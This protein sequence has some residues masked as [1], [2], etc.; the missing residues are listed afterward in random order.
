MNFLDTVLPHDPLPVFVLVMMF[1]LFLP[2]IFER[3]K[4]PGL[5]GLIISGIILGPQ[6]LNI[7]TPDGPIIKFLADVGKLMVMFFAGLEIDM[8]QFKR[9][10][11]K[12]AIYGL[13]TFSFPLITGF[14]V[15]IIFGYSAISSLLIGSL[16]A[17][18]TLLAIPILIR[19]KIIKRES[20]TIT[21][22]ATMFT[23]I[24]SLVVL[25]VCI[26]IHTVGFNAA[27]LS[28][29]F[30]GMAVFIP[31]L[32]LISKKI[33]P[34]CLNR[35]QASEDSQTLYIFLIMIIAAVGAEKIHLEG[36]VGAFIAGLAVGETIKESPIREKLDTIGNTFFIPMFFL[37]V[38]SI[39]NPLSF[40]SMSAGNIIFMIIVISG[41][42]FSKYIAALITGKIFKYGKNDILCMWSLSIPQV[43]ATMAA[44]LVASQALD[45][46]GQPLIDQA[47]LDTI[48]VLVM[49]TAIIGPILT[50]RYTVRIKAD[51]EYIL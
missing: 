7:I 49:L 22:G 29:R 42:F 2:R 48:L 38:G 23:D 20:I 8:I 27:E 40:L 12:S 43:A 13:A 3:F 26:A 51:D 47:T 24:A 35:M 5:V 30:V 32:L 17:S 16:L 39:I 19:D 37:L 45:S 41:L 28:F 44:A 6:M 31:A 18:H 14:M 15:S 4:I 36:I 46:A 33:I 9:T 25:A 10:G 34:A 1:I 11:H 50:Q 21:I